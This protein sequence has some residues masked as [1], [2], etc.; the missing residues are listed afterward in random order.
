MLTPPFLLRC[1][2]CWCAYCSAVWHRGQ[3]CKLN[4]SSALVEEYKSYAEG[5]DGRAQ[6]ERRF[7]K[8]N[9]L[10]LVSAFEE[11][12]ANEAWLEGNSVKCP[13]CGVSSYACNVHR[14][15]KL[16][17]WLPRRY[18]LSAPRAVRI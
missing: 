17:L 10:R 9:L 4:A 5:S 2:Y 18:A 1:T 6:M 8:A 15:Y 11:Q 7:G 3:T 13:C 16:T 12:K 14:G